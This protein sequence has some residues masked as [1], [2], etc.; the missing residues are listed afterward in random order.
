MFDNLATYL[1]DEARRPLMTLERNWNGS[2]R[3]DAPWVDDVAGQWSRGCPGYLG[4]G[5]WTSYG[6]WIREPFGHIHFANSEHSTSYNTYVE[7]AIRSA[8]AVAQEILA[9]I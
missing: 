6:P 1:G 9:E 8:E 3:R 2:I 4:P 5:I 7:G